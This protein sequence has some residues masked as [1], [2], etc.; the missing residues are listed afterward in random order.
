MEF[1]CIDG[2]KWELFEELLPKLL[3]MQNEEREDDF[4][5]VLKERGQNIVYE[6]LRQLCEEDQ[7]E[8]PYEADAFSVSCFSRASLH[9]IQ[10]NLPP[11]NPSINDI[12]RAYIVYSDETEPLYFLI[13]HFKEGE[14]FILYV[15]SDFQVLK[16]DELT[17]HE[18]DR[19]FEYWKLAVNYLTI[20][21]DIHAEESE[22]KEDSGRDWQQVDWMSVREKIQRN[23][24]EIGLTEEEYQEF[25]QWYACNYRE[26]YDQTVLYLAFKEGKEADPVQQ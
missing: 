24:K 15:T 26:I 19:N 25:L 5:H 12:V 17:R 7:A 6:I 2:L 23:E 21:K 22:S 16:A 1:R 11:Y 10:M 14:T 9:F 13:K 20:Y 18:E 8:C 3:Y 4:F